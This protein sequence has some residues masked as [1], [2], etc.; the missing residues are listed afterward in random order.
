LPIDQKTPKA[1]L[2]NYWS[3]SVT[4]TLSGVDSEPEE[5][6]G[7]EGGMIHGQDGE[8]LVGEDCVGDGFVVAE[9]ATGRVLGSSDEPVCGDTVIIVTEDGTLQ[10]DP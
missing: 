1:E 10:D 3:E 9:T 5:F 2:V 7:R 8:L 6:V 4:L